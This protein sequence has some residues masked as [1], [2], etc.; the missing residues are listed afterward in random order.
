MLKENFVPLPAGEFGASKANYAFKM[1][2]TRTHNDLL[3]CKASRDPF[4]AT[5]KQT[6]IIGLMSLLARVQ[7]LLIIL[8]GTVKGKRRCTAKAVI[9]PVL[10]E[11]GSPGII[12]NTSS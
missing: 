3:L 8:P 4:T 5:M 9:V 10:D 1:A 7:S 12:T 11:H 2:M 6:E